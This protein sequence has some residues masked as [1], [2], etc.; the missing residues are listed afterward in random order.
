MGEEVLLKVLEMANVRGDTILHLAAAV[1]SDGICERVATKYL[2]L[3]KANADGEKP[4]FGL[5]RKRNARG[6]TPLFVAAHHGNLQA[7]LILHNAYTATA[8]DPQQTYEPLRRPKDGD[9][10]LH[11]AISGEYF[12]KFIKHPQ[13]L[14][15]NFE[16]SG[17]NVQYEM[18]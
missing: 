15:N 1:G 14:S 18:T 17:K 3:L 16:L 13:Y 10:I 8:T 9:T 5:M 4:I 11:A 12:S 7:F 6:E 2:S